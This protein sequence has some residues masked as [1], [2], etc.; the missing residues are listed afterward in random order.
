MKSAAWWQLLATIAGLILIWRTLAHSQDASTYAKET[1]DVA[2]AQL[3]ASLRVKSCKLSQDGLVLKVSVSYENVGQS[4]AKSVR[5]HA[6]LSLHESS[7]TFPKLFNEDDVRDEYPISLAQSDSKIS[8]I[9]FPN[10]QA[11]EKLKSYK[12][13]KYLHIN[14]IYIFT[15]IF[16]EKSYLKYAFQIKG[17]EIDKQMNIVTIMH[18]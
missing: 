6:V 15:D 11:T 10:E 3:K 5:S 12:S 17:P 14:G 9:G 13:G 18:S 4:M 2:K 7:A 16:G 8:L 1:V